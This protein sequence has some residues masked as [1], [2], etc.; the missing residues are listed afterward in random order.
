[1][2]PLIRAGSS[3]HRTPF[4]KTRSPGT[5][6]RHELQRK[7]HSSR[8][9]RVEHGTAHLKNWRTLPATSAAAST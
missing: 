5:K 8:R 7:A 2:A 1:M 6:E 4:K 9:I 3:H